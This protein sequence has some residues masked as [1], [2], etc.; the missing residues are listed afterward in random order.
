MLA[1]R[2]A[3]RNSDTPS[4]CRTPLPNSYSEFRHRVNVTYAGRE[5]CHTTLPFDPE[6]GDR[7]LGQRL[8]RVRLEERPA[9]RQNDHDRLVHAGTLV[10]RAST[11][12]I[13]LP[14]PESKTVNTA[15][16]SDP[17]P[18]AT[19]GCR[20]SDSRRGGIRRPRDATRPLGCA[21]RPC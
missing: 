13:F 1:S 3:R 11:S 2:A 19:A 7:R 15:A 14:L 21:C 6:P 5:T 16:M 8:E 20:P 4:T 17:P 9:G 18:V 12:L 10:G